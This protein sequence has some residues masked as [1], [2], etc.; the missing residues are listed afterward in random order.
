MYQANTNRYKENQVLLSNPGEILLALYDGA[1]KSGRQAKLA[2]ED[3]NPALKGEK[4][5]GA[6]DIL[7]ELSATLDHEK[8]PD[9]CRQ[10]AL[11][12][13]Y[14]VERL[15]VA[16]VDMVTEPVDEVITH[17]EKLRA[18]WGEAVQTAKNE[19]LGHVA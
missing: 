6:I 2:I 18:T 16:N 5:G 14:L 15:L 3:N 12:Y 7:A 9:L 10:L 19:A 1:I 4:I 11:L 8:A 17:L 13:D